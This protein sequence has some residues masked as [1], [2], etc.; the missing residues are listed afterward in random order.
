MNGYLSDNPTITQ[1]QGLVV[2]P[3]KTI[4]LNGS[5][6][7][8]DVTPPSLLTNGTPHLERIT[9]SSMNAT[10]SPSHSPTPSEDAPSTTSAPGSDKHSAA[11]S[12]ASI[13]SPLPPPAT[14]PVSGASSSTSTSASSVSPPPGPSPKLASGTRR[15]ST[16]RHVP[17]RGANGRTPLPSSPLRPSGNHA[18]TS[19]NL[20][21]SSRQLDPT[22][23]RY[24]ENSSRTSS[25]RSTPLLAPN[26]RMSMPIIP[27]LDLSTQSPASISSSPVPVSAIPT[28]QV[29][30]PVPPTPP[31]KSTPA[32]T[33]RATPEPQNP[34]PSATAISA[35]SSQSSQASRKTVRGRAPYSTNFQP[36][37]FYRHRTDEFLE[38]RKQTRDSG[39]IERT[40]LERRLEKLIN[41]HFP[42]PSTVNRRNS[43]QIPTG[44][45]S[46]N[47]TGTLNRRASSIF[48][49]SFADLKSKSA[50]DL[51]KGVVQSPSG[52][53]VDTRGALFRSNGCSF[54]LS[55]LLTTPCS[56]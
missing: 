24:T 20:T 12:P 56:C 52:S 11:A 41:L 37:G 5:N 36:P 26:E 10:S 23:G 8:Y 55:L 15:V 31:P 33:T 49:I 2:D 7:V 6:R 54:L 13:N 17:L 45:T 43:L 42:N 16:F 28:P 29:P 18:R 48:D 1:N 38:A 32:S 4:P 3:E 9:P 35:Q 46:N 47:R 25:T 14:L 40:R 27:S 51:W 21:T 39:R 44:Q 34:P 22:T 50:S 19:S 30:S 53:K